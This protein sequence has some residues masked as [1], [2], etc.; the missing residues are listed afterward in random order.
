MIQLTRKITAARLDQVWCSV[1]GIMED[2]ENVY[3]LI[4]EDVSVNSYTVPTT[5]HATGLRWVELLNVPEVVY[6]TS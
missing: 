4:C 6:E 5:V 2:D 1:L 3:L